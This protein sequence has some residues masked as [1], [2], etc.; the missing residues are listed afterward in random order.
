[1]ALDAGSGD[2]CCPYALSLD[3][4]G[5]LGG[6]STA[7]SSVPCEE[8]LLTPGRAYRQTPEGSCTIWA[9]SGE[10]VIELPPGTFCYSG[11]GDAGVGDGG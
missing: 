5:A 8:R 2:E 10:C 11:G 3:R 1:M 9:D 7:L 6:G 4:P